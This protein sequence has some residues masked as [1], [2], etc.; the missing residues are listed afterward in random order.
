MCT[1]FDN[2]LE[3]REVAKEDTT[4]SILMVFKFNIGSMALLLNLLTIYFA[5]EELCKLIDCAEIDEMN[6]CILMLSQT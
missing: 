1:H 5:K 4:Y 2:R 3:H 6:T